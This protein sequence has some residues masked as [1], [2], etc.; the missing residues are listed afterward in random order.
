MAWDPTHNYYRACL[1]WHLSFNM[2]PEEVHA[3]GLK[4][5]DRISG[6]MNQIVRKIGLRGSVKDFFDSLLNDSRFY[7]N[8]SDIILEQYRKTVFERINPQLSRFFKAIP[9]VPLKV[10]KSAF[11]GNGGTY[12]GASE[13]TP[14]VFS[15]NLFRPLEVFV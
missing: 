4:E 11:D 12:S 3:V 5:V 6:N 8:N 9:N 7:S 1:R 15:V 10:E 13:D 2:T 14:G